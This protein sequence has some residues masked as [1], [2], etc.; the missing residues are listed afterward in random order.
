M[1]STIEVGFAGLGS[2]PATCS[3][4]DCPA[5]SLLALPELASAVTVR[6]AETVTDRCIEAWSMRR[7][8]EP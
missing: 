5:S 8:A 2:T 1:H 6:E 3:R 7:Q 4:S